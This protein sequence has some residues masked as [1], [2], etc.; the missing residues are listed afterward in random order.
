MNT[1]KVDRSGEMSAL[2]ATKHSSGFGQKKDYRDV[3][4]MKYDKTCDHCKMKGHTMD[5]CFKLVG[6]PEWYSTLK[7]KN[8][9]E[10]AAHVQDAEVLGHSPLDFDGNVDENA[11]NSSHSAAMNPAMMNMFKEFTKM[12]Q[13]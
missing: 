8:Q 3:K 5:S 12:M 4:R 9:P 2:L 10:L 7:G 11:T 13:Q 1:V 6:Y